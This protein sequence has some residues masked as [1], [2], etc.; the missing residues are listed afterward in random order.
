[1]NRKE[2]VMQKG[3]WEDTGIFTFNGVVTGVAESPPGLVVRFEKTY[4]FP[5]S[6]GQLADG[7]T[8]GSYPL[9]DAQQ[10]DD[11]PYVVLAK[12]ALVAVG[13][14][15]RC[16][17]DVEKRL[18]HTQL[19]TAQHILSR[20]L[21]DA[22]I[23]T[24]SFHMTEDQA[25]I[26]I[27]TPA[28]S[29]DDVSR[30]EDQV[31]RVIWSCLPVQTVLV[32]AADLR[33][34]NV[35]KVPELAGGP[36]RLVRIGEMDTNPCGGTHVACTGEIGSFV[37]TGMDR[38]RGNVRLYFAA[39]RTATA[40]HRKE[41]LALAGAERLLTCGAAD[42]VAAVARLQQRDRD[43]DKQNRGLLAMAVKGLV[44]ESEE[45]ISRVGV[46]VVVV[47]GAPAELARMA[48]AEMSASTGPFCV[49]VYPTGGND[50]LFA[51]TVPAGREDL[52]GSFGS[53][54]KELYGARLGGSGRSLQG[55]IT[56]RVAPSELEGLLSNR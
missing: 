18:R 4:F 48:A 20:L 49:V 1:M 21:D 8:V 40:H 36:L 26:E 30:I 7:G 29:E 6:G 24:L 42:V 39:G 34:Y 38:V 19:H 50:G 31:E 45:R 53:R 28:L 14:V 23:R 25:S 22:G 15:V 33:N 54:L 10:D 44:R 17:V 43:A 3:Y 27:D 47:D 32:S 55:K 52:L 35:R 5:E 9:V 37:V 51:C 46:A 13:D 2:L 16:S 41:H 11:G 56:A 12:G